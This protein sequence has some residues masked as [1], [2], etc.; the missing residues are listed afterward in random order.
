[1]Q[2]GFNITRHYT[3][4]KKSNNLRGKKPLLFPVGKDDALALPSTQSSPLIYSF[5]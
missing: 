2:L 1:M 4:S 3:Q 5:L